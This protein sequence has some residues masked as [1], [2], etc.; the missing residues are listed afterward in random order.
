MATENSQAAIGKFLFFLAA[1]VESST[2]AKYRA[3]LSASEPL[4]HTDSKGDHHVSCR[5]FGLVTHQSKC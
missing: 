2:T 3:F 4:C 1:I 5:S